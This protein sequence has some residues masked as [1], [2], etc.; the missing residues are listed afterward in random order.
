M[1]SSQI[2]EKCSIGEIEF[3]IENEG[4]IT[5]YI[6]ILPVTFC[7]FCTTGIVEIGE[8]MNES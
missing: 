5:G 2:I 6:G 8:K 7:P 1:G 3:D 4:G